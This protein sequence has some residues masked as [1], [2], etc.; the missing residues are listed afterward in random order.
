MEIFNMKKLLLLSVIFILAFICT[1][2]VKYSYNIEVGNDDKIAISKTQAMNLK[3]FENYDPQFDKKFQENIAESEKKFKEQGFE[4]SAYKDNI[5]T[6]LTL[7]KKDLSFANAIDSLKDD[8]KNDAYAFL[9]QRH[10]LN[11]HYKIHLIYDFNKVLNN[12]SDNQDSDGF[13]MQTPEPTEEQESNIVSKT[14]ETDSETG[15]VIETTTYDNGMTV[16]TRKNP[17]QEEKFGKALGSALAETPG[18]KPVSELTIKIPKKATNHNAT[19]VI[20]DTEYYWDLTGESQPVEIILE[21]EKF[22]SAILSILISVLICLGFLIIVFNK[23]K[24]E[25]LNGF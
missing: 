10:G 14:S 3:F 24:A 9:V 23:T 7:T 11:K 18:L 8:F 13:A 2:C 1:G 22:D 16:T 20:S 21:Y 5:Y 17:A 19:K 4:T 25:D 6:G 12:V 15:E